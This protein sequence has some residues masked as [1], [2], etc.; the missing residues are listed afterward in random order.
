MKPSTRSASIADRLGFGRFGQRGT[1]GASIPAQVAFEDVHVDYGVTRALDG[2]SLVV[3]PGELVC[4]LGHSGCGKT[5]LLRV[6]SGIETPTAGRVMLD[7]REV[8]GQAA[9]VPPEAR[10]IGLMFQDYALFPH[11][12]I[13]ENVL[14]GLKSLP[15][16]DAL[17]SATRALSRVGL[18]RL[19]GEHP[20]VL[21]GGEQQRVALARAIAPRPGVLLMDEP[22]SNLDR[23]LRD[24]IRE[25]T[26]A[27]LRETGATTIVVTHDPEEAMRIADRIVLMRAGRVVQEGPAEAIYRRPAD[28][29]AARFF[30]DFNEVE[31]VVRRGAVET[32]IG[33]FPAPGL[34]EGEGAIVCVRPQAIRLRAPGFC[35][36]GRI[37]ARRFLGEVDLVH[38][39]VQGLDAPLQGRCRDGLRA[40]E[41]QDVGVDVD[42]AE[43]LVFATH[44]H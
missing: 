32:P 10:G 16:A 39:A 19:S 36:P 31:G 4:L 11:M 23:R 1:A 3:E 26:V 41:G 21:S 30:C 18:E 17:A 22:F 33:R 7:G 5:T 38:V 9:F 37:V 29:F 28:L 25:E 20:H 14:F 24:T 34:A 40:G 12:T 6:A 42:P 43:V 2:V 27:I 44:R 13:L 35:L 15:K 8:S